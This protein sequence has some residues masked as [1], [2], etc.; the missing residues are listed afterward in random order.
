MACALPLTPPDFVRAA[1][2]L[3]RI[4][5]ITAWIS[6]GLSSGSGEGWLLLVV[7]MVS[8]EKSVVLS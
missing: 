8:F 1:V 2:S 4:R 6:S 3:A 5:S 7:D